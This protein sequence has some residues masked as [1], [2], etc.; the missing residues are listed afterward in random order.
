MDERPAGI[1][2]KFKQ[3]TPWALG[4][5]GSALLQ[6]SALGRV[7]S[8]LF[9]DSLHSINASH[10]HLH[11]MSCQRLAGAGTEVLYTVWRPKLPFLYVS[12]CPG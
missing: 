1:G 11:H 12:F 9:Q 5:H 3:C 4:K 6:G 8:K 2:P 7:W 10:V